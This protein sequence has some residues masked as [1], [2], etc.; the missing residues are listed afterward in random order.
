MDK[1]LIFVVL[2]GILLLVALIPVFILASVLGPWLQAF[3]AGVPLSL[4]QILGMRLRRTNVRSVVQALIM[5]T[6]AGVPVP[7][8]EME[9]AYLQGADL[10]KVTLALI[11]THRSGKSVPF[12]ELVEADLEN[13]L[14][15]KLS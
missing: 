4:L 14:Q 6:Q 1:T 3:M 12:Q 7:C 8:V 11:Q 9:R 5:A 15:A 13:R 2:A 10:D